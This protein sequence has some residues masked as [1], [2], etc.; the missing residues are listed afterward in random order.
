MLYKKPNWLF[1][2]LIFPQGTSTNEIDVDK[3]LDDCQLPTKSREKNILNKQTRS[4]NEKEKSGK[5]KNIAAG[6]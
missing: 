2:K 1:Q 6:T 3:V 5:K 4:P